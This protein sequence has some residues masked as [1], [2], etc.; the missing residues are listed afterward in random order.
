MH[1]PRS[2]AGPAGR[3][4]HQGD[5]RAHQLPS[6]HEAAVAAARLHG[7]LSHLSAAQ[8]H[9]WE[10]AKDPDKPWV[11]VPRN[12]KVT[13][14]RGVHLVY[15]DARGTVTS[16]VQTVLD[17]ARR[18]P[19]GEALSVADSAL[20]HGVDPQH[21]SAAAGAARGPGA[22][23]CRRVAREAT[24]LAANPLESS[25]RAIVLEVPGLSVKPQVPI[26]LPGL[27]VHPDLVDTDLGIVIEAEGWLF[28][29]VSREQFSR[30]LW[31]YTMLVVRGWLV[32]R[33]GYRQVM[34]RPDYVFEALMTLVQ[35]GRRLP[36][37]IHP[38]ATT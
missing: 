16:P 3:A 7:T 36:G 34:E 22:G 4:D 37:S 29:G 38:R 17:C 23:R 14:T 21:L 31:R 28:H 9:G 12:R 8:H 2:P 20:R 10:L 1:L 25:L 35:T 11:S 19:F 15:G 27:L 24:P 18:L 26:Q 33:F 6:A 30:D 32:V 13:T 5:A